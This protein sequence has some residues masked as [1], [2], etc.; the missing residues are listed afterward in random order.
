MSATWPGSVVLPQE[1]GTYDWTPRRAVAVVVGTG[2][3]YYLGAQV[4]LA[5]TIRPD[6]VSVLWPPNATLIAALLLTPTRYWWII[7]AAALPAHVAVQLQGGVPIP[8]MLCW[9]VS[10]CFEALLGAAIMRRFSG[11]RGRIESMRALWVFVVGVS[12]FATFASSFLDA[13]FVVLN[14][15]GESS[16][17]HV[18]RTRFFANVL[19]TQVI[20]PAILSLDSRDWSAGLNMTVRRSAEAAML[21]ALTLAVCVAAFV[22]M[23]PW[24]VGPSLLYAPLPVLL[25]AA[26]RFRSRGVNVALLVVTCLAIRG[27]VLGGG[28]F[29]GLEPEQAAR[30]IQIFLVLVAIPLQMLA[31]LIEERESAVTQSRDRQRLHALTLKAARIGVW[32]VDLATGKTVVDEQ[33]ATMFDLPPW[34]RRYLSSWMIRMHPADRAAF[35]ANLQKAQEST[36]PRDESDDSPIPE[37]V[38][39]VLYRDISWRWILT[40]GIVLRRADGTPYRA[41]GIGIDVTEPH[42]SGVAI[43]E[44]EER[45]ELAAA[46]ADLG[47]WSL[48]VV[49]GDLWMSAHCAAMLGIEGYQERVGRIAELL[50]GRD[51][52]QEEPRLLDT[53]APASPILVNEFSIVRASGDERWIATTARRVRG[54][55]GPSNR[56]IGVVRDVT[57]RRRRDEEVV[58]REQALAH[59]ARVATMGELSGTMVHELGQPI[60]AVMLNAESARVLLERHR[61]QLAGDSDEYRLLSAIMDDVVR[62]IKRADIVINQLRSFMRREQI[63]R[64]VAGLAAIVAEVLD[65]VRAELTRH[66]IVV[67]SDVG[68]VPMPI[69]VNRTQMHQV[70]INLILNARDAMAGV[71]VESRRLRITLRH[72]PASNYAHLII[73]DSGMGIANERLSEVF[74][75]FVTSKAQ[76]VGLG[77]AISRS[78]MVEHGGDLRAETGDGGAVLHLTLPL[79]PGAVRASDVRLSDAVSRAPER[80][81]A[82]GRYE[83][84]VDAAP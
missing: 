75:P 29:S 51:P 70:L 8:M 67:E 52:T 40:R 64:E 21:V 80:V 14:G 11:G 12:L 10:N 78:I 38:C 50:L 65:L 71:P 60:G 53:P 30:S 1:A 32:D 28:P 2:I 26:V 72:D 56:I 31:M 79:V 18:W 22:L 68:S 13:G 19:A 81:R 54:D 24:H 83:P 37:A 48:D 49:S 17:W 44:N 20:V 35:K 76:G 73:A 45:M 47:F 62:D 59:L 74:E 39:R 66:D 25:W 69:L 15:W 4:G 55:A 36:A 23:P 82:P 6:T 7:I 27:A 34:D 77:L 46:T 63:E 43:R 84:N 3:A 9:F 61:A 42:Q 16:Y 33:F 41:T 57:E 5:L 58:K